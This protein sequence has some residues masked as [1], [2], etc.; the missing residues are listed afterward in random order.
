LTTEERKEWMEKIDAEFKAKKK[1][2]TTKTA[3][4]KKTTSKKTSKTKDE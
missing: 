2:S 4:T 1:T 3:A